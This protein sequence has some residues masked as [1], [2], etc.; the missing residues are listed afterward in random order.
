MKLNPYRD[1]EK[2]WMK[3]CKHVFN[4]GEGWWVVLG[5]LAGWTKDWN[6]L[7]VVGCFNGPDGHLA[8]SE[9]LDARVIANRNHS[10]WIEIAERSC[11]EALLHGRVHA[12][13]AATTARPTC[14][15]LHVVSTT[16]DEPLDGFRETRLSPSASTNAP[17]M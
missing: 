2:R 16:T 15:S 9:H 13:L 1:V 11:D 7:R 6:T 4:P 3:V 14:T 5:G 12:S 8:L 17:P 10:S